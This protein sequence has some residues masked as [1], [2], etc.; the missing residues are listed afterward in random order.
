MVCGV[1]G[2]AGI[3]LGWCVTPP[4][5]TNVQ[6]HTRKESRNS[7]MKELPIWLRAV[8]VGGTALLLFALETRQALRAPRREKRSVHT[9][10][11]LA[12]A[13]LAGLAMTIV[14]TPLLRRVAVYV[15]AMGWGLAPLLT[16]NPALAQPSGVKRIDPD[17]PS[18]S[19]S[20]KPVK[21]SAPLF[22]RVMR[23]SGEKSINA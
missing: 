6:A 21:R 11:N 19:A 18:T 13:G 20:L 4:A 23:L 12:I 10:R 9:S 14:E 8:F 3:V 7:R 15:D 2:I 16:R 22:Q 17:F 1:D 5:G